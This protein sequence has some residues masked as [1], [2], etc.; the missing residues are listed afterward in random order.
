MFLNKWKNESV[1]TSLVVQ[2]LRLL[3]PNAGGMGLIPGQ[4]SKTH[5]AP[6]TQHKPPPHTKKIEKEWVNK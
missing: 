3:A 4:G 5:V 1:G 2:W 6:K